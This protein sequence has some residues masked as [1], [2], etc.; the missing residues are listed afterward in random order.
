MDKEFLDSLNKHDNTFKRL[1]DREPA[2][3]LEAQSVVEHIRAEKGY[4]DAEVV[5][6]LHGNSRRTQEIIFNIVKLKRETEAAYTT[7]ISEQLYSSKYRFLY[8]L[9]QNADDSVF[10]G[11]DRKRLSPFLRFEVNPDSLIVETNEDGFRRRNVEAICATGRSSKKATKTDDH[12]GEKGFGF[13]SVFSIADDVHIQSGLWSFRFRHRQGEDG[14]GMVTPLDASPEEL[15]PDVTT[16]M[17]L[18]FTDDARQSYARLLIAIQDIPD[19]TLLFLRRLR[20]I[21]FIVTNISGQ[22]E[23]TFFSRR[24]SPLRRVISRWRETDDCSLTEDCTY[25]LFKATRL[26]MPHHERRKDR[27]EAQVELAF[28]INSDNGQ[29]KLSASGHHVF[30]FLPLQRVAQLQFLIHSDF[31]TSASRESV[32]DCAWNDALYDEVANTFATAVSGTFATSDHALRYAWLD[33]LPEKAMDHPWKTLYSALLERIQVQNVFQTMERRQFKSLLQVRDVATAAL[34]QGKPILS[35][36]AD[37]VYLASE[38]TYSHKQRLVELG[39]KSI[40]WF[41]FLDRLQAD[42]VSAQSKIRTTNSADPWHEAFAKL[43]VIP[44]RTQSRNLD[45]VRDRIKKLALIPLTGRNQWTGAPNI[46]FGGSTNV[47]FA[48][49]GTTPI[50]ERLSLRLLDKIASQNQTRRA[51]YKAL[52]VEDCPKE[53]VFT[54]IKARHSTIRFADEIADDLRYMYH[55][56]YNLEDIRSWVCVSALFFPGYAARARDLELYLPSGGEFDMYNLI[57]SHKSNMLCLSP[58]SHSEYS[59]LSHEIFHAE[60]PAVRVN[61]IDWKTWL[62]HATG[63][64]YFLLLHKG[65]GFL[66]KFSDRL[67][68]GLKIVLKQN[69]AK[70]LSTLRAHWSV[71][72]HSAHVVA[73]ELGACS[74]PCKSGKS[75]SLNTTYLPTTEILAEIDRLDLGE[76]NLPLLALPEGKLDVKSYRTWR[77]LEDFGVTSKPD[78]RLYKIAIQSKS[79]SSAPDLGKLVEIYRSIASL[80]TLAEYTSLRSLF[81]DDYLIWDSHETDWVRSSE[82]ILDGPEFIT[83]KSVLPRSYERDDLLDGFFANILEIPG[84]L[85]ED[86][87]DEITHRHENCPDDTS[88]PIMHDIYAFLDSKASNDDD[89]RTIKARFKESKMI[90]GEGGT[91]HTLETCVWH[92]PFALSDFQDLSPLYNSLEEFFVK[93]LN[94]KKASP[95]LLINEVKRMAE[96]PSPCVHDIRT[97]LIEIGMMLARTSINGS[98]SKALMS[99]KDTKFLPKKMNDGVSALVGKTDDFAIADHRRYCDAL[100]DQDVLL[101]FDVHEVQILHVVFEHMGLTQ[102]Y[103]SAMVREVSMVGETLLKDEQLSQQLHAKAYALYCCAAKYKSSKALRNDSALFE[104]IS[105]AIIYTTD[106]ITTNLVLSLPSRFISVESDRLAINHDLFDGQIEIY[107]PADEQQRRSCYRSQLPKVLATILKVPLIATFDISSIVSCSLLD[108]ENVLIEQDISSVEWIEQPVIF[109]PD[110]VL[111]ERPSTPALTIAESEAATLVN[112]GVGPITPEATPM[113]YRRSVSRLDPEDFIETAPPEQYPDLIE[114]V[115]G[116]ARQAGHRYRNVEADEVY[117]PIL[118]SQNREFDHSATFGVRSGNGFI[119]D[120]RIGAAGEA[121]VFE[122]LTTLNIPN[123]TE[124]NWRSTIR[125]E[126]SRSTRFA[127]MTNWTGRETADIV[128]KDTSGVLTQ[129]LRDHS[130]GDFPPQI[131]EDHNFDECP[132]EYYLEVKSTTGPCGTRFYMSG[133]QYKRMEMMKLGQLRQPSKVYV[134]MRVFDLMTAEVDMKIFVDPLG[135]PGTKLEFE[136]D[137]WFVTTK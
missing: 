39:L 50:P 68:V 7:N 65:I 10:A 104:Q 66:H 19:T 3:Y 135:Q 90:L 20:M 29:P 126:L 78:L 41:E 132:I 107:V 116:S 30:A 38:Y 87:L 134:L 42:L 74:V 69:P 83:F 102:R 92:S 84:L 109:I 21:Q 120:R 63:A 91:W 121:Y 22:R 85:L 14:L 76:D 26:N 8:E 43:M 32:V 2:T 58:P 55:Q 17:V 73:A 67:S 12:I 16:R 119:H 70:F 136:A 48:F 86:I 40:T 117:E 133:G 49:T 89:W 60:P 128:Y 64:M 106:D 46:S 82:C 94:V 125:G 1:G 105:Q 54:K 5:R 137:Q 114:Q 4:L 113:R 47:Y 61:D 79:R 53:T 110:V 129:Y 101:D 81:G 44:F 37:D 100:A 25:L 59:I 97:R 111:E 62:V 93:R 27:I 95:S 11:A 18:R 124:A 34:Y 127:D 130:E 88:I 51:F 131:R 80:A 36:L 118:R 28:P 123:F 98:V 13:K 103:L 33:Y 122:L 35:D 31:V 56:C 15:P 72:Q 75:V 57:P 9:I 108:L 115:V 96:T 52:G 23:K 112:T 45:A 6:E 71:Y 77:F 24:D 99:L